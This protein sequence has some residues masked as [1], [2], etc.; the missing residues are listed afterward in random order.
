MYLSLPFLRK[1]L[2]TAVPIPL[3][4]LLIICYWLPHPQ[5]SVISEVVLY[6]LMASHPV[7]CPPLIRL[8]SPSSSPPHLVFGVMSCMA[9]MGGQ[10]VLV[11][12]E[13]RLDNDSGTVIISISQ[14]FIFPLCDLRWLLVMETSLC[15]PQNTALC[16]SPCLSTSLT[17]WA[18]V[19]D[20]FAR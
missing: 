13:T 6:L 20:W 15:G 16:K 9:L 17:R 3:L 5:L 19:G 14:L 11:R 18:C 2:R 12:C 7:T 4:R 10:T 1:F 8:F